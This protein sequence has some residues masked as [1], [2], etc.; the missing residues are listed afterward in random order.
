MNETGRFQSLGGFFVTGCPEEAKHEWETQDAAEWHTMLFLKAQMM[1]I[2]SPL[3]GIKLTQCDHG[4]ANTM[5][6]YEQN[7]QF[8]DFI[9]IWGLITIKKVL[10]AFDWRGMRWSFKH[11]AA[12]H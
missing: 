2:Y 5:S 3:T 12:V 11:R 9:A 7:A 4:K 1:L 6:L 8:T 10:I